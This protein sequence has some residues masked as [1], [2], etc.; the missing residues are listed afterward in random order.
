MALLIAFSCSDDAAT[1]AAQ[2]LVRGGGD[3][4]GVGHGVGVHAGGDQARVV[5]HVHHEDRTH[6]LGH[7]GKARKVDVQAVGRGT[8]DD[9]LGLGFVGLLFHRFVVDGF[10]GIQAVGDHV[11]P[12]ARHVQRHAVR[13]VAAFCQAHAHDGVAGL[14][15]SQEHGLVG[16]CAAVGLY[17]GG[18]GA[19]DLLDAVDG[20]LL[21]HVYMLAAAVVALAGV[22][23]G[24]LVGQLRALGPHDGGRG[25][26][27]AGN[28]LD[29]LFLALVFGLDGSKEFGVGLFDK[30][31]AVVHGSPMN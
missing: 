30:N 24:V 11:E 21:G 3:H 6:V 8:G 26:V 22:A 20:Q 31:I 29:V 19:E 13:Q 15:E 27:F 7:L 17:V 10:V 18:F 23:F 14:E 16:R 12:L 28:Q 25:V 5:G 4:V 1:G 9:E 2:A